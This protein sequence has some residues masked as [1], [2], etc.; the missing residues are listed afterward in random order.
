MRFGNF[1]VL[2]ITLNTGIFPAGAQNLPVKAGPVVAYSQPI[3]G[4]P[5]YISAAAVDDSG[6]VY[7]SGGAFYAGGA[8]VSKVN[9][10][11]RVWT[12]RIGGSPS[13]GAGAYL[14]EASA[15]AVDGAGNVYVA[16]STASRDFPVVNALQPNPGGG[17]DAFLTKLSP[18]GKLLFSTYLGGSGEDFAYG[19]AV[20]RVGNVYVTGGT[21]S[22]NFPTAAPIQAKLRGARDAF[23]LK[24][25]TSGTLVYSTYLGGSGD[26]EMGRRIVAD[27]A[28][29]AYIIGFTNSMDFPTMDASQPAAG[30]GSCRTGSSLSSPAQTH[31]LPSSTPPASWLTPPILAAAGP[32]M[33][34]RL[35]WTAPVMR[36]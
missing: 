17:W 2:A 13:P 19:V 26:L 1:V 14:D 5:Q 30:G 23:V 15:V 21:G 7:L 11:G 16:G 12:V 6:N 22:D 10:T 25:E 3:P 18:E 28:G 20:D 34:R 29:N 35:P 32:I 9:A 4:L 31:S 27:Q 8:Y 33:G 36:T 24:L